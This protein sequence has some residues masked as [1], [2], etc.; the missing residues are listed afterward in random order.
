MNIRISAANRCLLTH[1]Y[2]QFPVRPHWTKNTRTIFGQA[3]KNLD[4]DVRPSL[5]SA[6]S[7]SL[8]PSSYFF[9]CCE[10]KGNADSATEKI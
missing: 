7:F 9:C 1:E 4:Q 8:P 6:P 2:P 10:A 5:L 3:V